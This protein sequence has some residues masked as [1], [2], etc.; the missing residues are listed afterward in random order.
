MEALYTAGG[1][2]LAFKIGSLAVKLVLSLYA[3]LLRPGKNLKSLGEWAGDQ[4]SLPLT[5]S[6]DWRN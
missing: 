1:L 3:M 2:L 6:G 4:L 5:D